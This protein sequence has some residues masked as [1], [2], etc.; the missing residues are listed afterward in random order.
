MSDARRNVQLMP[1]GNNSGWSYWPLPRKL[2]LASFVLA[3]LMAVFLGLSWVA[4]GSF[5]TG[6]ALIWPSPDNRQYIYQSI[7]EKQRNIKERVRNRRE[8]PYRTS[9]LKEILSPN[10]AGVVRRKRLEHVQPQI[11]PLE[12]GTYGFLPEVYTPANG[13]HVLYAVADGHGAAVSGSPDRIISVSNAFSRVLAEVAS[14]AGPGV[15]GALIHQRVPYSIEKAVAYFE[16]FRLKI[17]GDV[18]DEASLAPDQQNML[19][20]QR[21]YLTLLARKAEQ[22][23]D[24]MSSIALSV[25]R[26]RSWSKSPIDRIPSSDIRKALGY[27][28]IELLTE[29]LNDLKVT[30]VRR[31]S[32]YDL[33]TILT[34]ST[35][36]TEIHSLYADKHV[37]MSRERSGELVNFADSL[38]MRRGFIP[39]DWEPHSKYLRIGGTYHRMFFIPDFPNQAIDAGL[40]Q[41]LFNGPY[42]IWY[43]FSTVY[44]TI[45]IEKERRRA[46][47]RRR[48]QDSRSLERAQR[49]SSGGAKEASEAQ[50]I[51]TLDEMLYRSRDDAV[52]ANFFAWANGDTLDN[53]EEASGV[54]RKMFRD[55]QLPL[56]PVVGQSL[57]VPVRLASL[58]V[59]SDQL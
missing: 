38:V 16:E 4:L 50:T 19:Q 5:L 6:F 36:L 48:E 18:S 8:G 31:A 30:G 11:I 7:I 52:K 26:P 57:Q 29:R 59:R 37:D 43:G 27:R 49:G 39:P 17:M 23:N 56:Q 24:F 58:G 46:T 25:P 40:L 32:P 14:E 44:E 12:G 33:A 34:A 15:Y 51:S 3:A 54:L 10:D 45:P 41:H 20:R 28:M 2:I 42:G 53:L 55:V 35:D 13:R 21:D 1:I 47:R 9:G 22:S